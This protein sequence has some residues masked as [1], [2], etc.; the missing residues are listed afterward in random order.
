MPSGTRRSVGPVHKWGSAGSVRQVV[1]WLIGAFIFGATVAYRVYRSGN[2]DLGYILAISGCVVVAIAIV[3]PN[4][5]SGRRRDPGDWSQEIQDLRSKHE[6]PVVGPR[7][8]AGDLERSNEKRD[9][10]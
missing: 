5:F 9:A 7:D 8:V 6:T 3:A 1:L 10:V 4:F 2:T